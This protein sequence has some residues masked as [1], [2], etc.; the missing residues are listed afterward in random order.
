[1]T[2]LLRP[3]PVGFTC[4]LSIRYRLDNYCVSKS[5]THP[6]WSGSLHRYPATW[7][8]ILAYNEKGR[9]MDKPIRLEPLQWR[10]N[11]RDGVSNH[12]RL[13]CLVSRLFRRRSK[14]TSKLCVTGLCEGNLPV[15]PVDSP[16]KE[17]VTRKCLYLM[18]SLWRGRVFMQ[19]SGLVM[20][21]CGKR[22]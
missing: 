13:D 8:G 5:H 9:F 6:Q 10:R 12:R 21:A 2:L 20:R 15:T 4:F 7:T 16:H 18:T 11:E 3:V 22:Y 1:M 17:P 14:N 19:R